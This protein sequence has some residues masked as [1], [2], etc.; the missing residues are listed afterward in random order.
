METIDN[1]LHFIQQHFAREL[2]LET[3]AAEAHYSPYHFHRLFKQQ[4][5]EAPRQYL[6][7]LRLEKATKELLFYPQKSVYAIAIDCGFSSQSVFARAFKSKYK[8]TAE[9]YRTT[10]QKAL[11]QKTDEI[12]IDVQQYPVTV[13]RTEPFIIACE[14]ILLQP[15]EG[16]M[17]AFRRLYN[18]ATAHELAGKQ[19]EYYGLFIDSPFTTPLHQCRYLAGI[20]IPHAVDNKECRSIGSMTIAQI[21]VMGDYSI[22][23]DYAVYVKQRW[24]PDSGY[25]IT[26]GVHGF[27][28]FT[29]IDFNKPYAAHFRTIC[30]GIRPK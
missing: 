14:M 18:W 1:I 9:Q 26:E 19:P 11:Q 10:A 20:R 24:V 3:L 22:L 23:T 28:R 27:E 4:V 12:T 8:L 17:Q 6:S 15:E 2:S 30:I 25:E 13:S 21:P 16:V 7:R 5:G 29:E